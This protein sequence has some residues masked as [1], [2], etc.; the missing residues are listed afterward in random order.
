[1]KRLYILTLVS[2]TLAVVIHFLKKGGNDSQLTVAAGEGLVVPK[3]WLFTNESPK[4]PTVDV[5]PADQTFLTFPEWFLVFSPEEQA[6]YYEHSTSTTFPFMSH[7]SQ[8]WD[9]YDI[10]KEQIDGNFPPNDGYHLMIKVIGSSSSVEYGVKAW[11]ETIVGRLTDTGAPKTEEDIFNARFTRDYVNFINDLPWY[12]YDFKKQ[13]SD[14]WTSTPIIGSNIIRKAER[15]YILTSELM[16]KYVYGKL[17]GL[18]TQQVY[19]E[20]LLTTAVILENDSLVH[21]PRYNRFADAAMKLSKEGHAFKE[22]AGNS[23][24]IL[25][26]VLQPTKS[27]MEFG[28]AKVLFTQLI[29]SDPRITRVALV[30]KVGELNKVL[31]RLEKEEEEGVVIE[32]V[33]DF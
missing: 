13:L 1:M 31:L 16:V 32:H 21:L 23:S 8:I 26:T 22:I 17:I 30:T 25:V 3:E 15:R 7:T 10:V 2:V 27:S 4:T 20:A 29:S 5:R 9:S 6:D 18:G 19:D 14:L 28:D 24:A 11:Y 33:F 12:Q